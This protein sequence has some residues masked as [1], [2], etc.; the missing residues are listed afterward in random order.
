MVV[1]SDGDISFYDSTG[2]TQGLFWDAS[3]QRLGLGTTAPGNKLSLPNNNYIAWKN[4]AGSS[5]TIAIRANT[6]DGLEFLTGS[7][8]MTITSGGNVGIGTDSPTDTAGF[9]VGLDVSSSTGAAVYVRDAGGS[10][11]G[12]FGQF[13]E[14][15]SIVSRQ[16]DGNIAFYTGASPSEKVRITSGG[17][18]GIGTSSPQAKAEISGGIDNR[19]RINSTDGT[20]L[21]N[22]GI[23]FSTAGT[24]HGGIRYNAGNNYLAFYGFNNTE[25]MRISSTGS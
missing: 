10:K 21:N 24:V 15:T 2:V 14:Q 4:N 18:V 7:T 22:Y 13:N 25:R 3:T 1:E 9:G 19:L 16:D 23:D 17:S 12:Y 11:T 20:T 8:R 5:E 6:S